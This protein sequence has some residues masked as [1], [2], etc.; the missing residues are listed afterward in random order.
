MKNIQN[1]HISAIFLLLAIFFVFAFFGNKIIYNQNHTSLSEAQYFS[2]HIE[3][4]S[5]KLLDVSETVIS[6][7]NT[8]PK[9]YWQK[10]DSTLVRSSYICFI[11]AGD[12][13]SYWSTNKVDVNAVNHLVH[14]NSI[15]V[16][17]LPS[18]WYLYISSK[19]DDL[20]ISILELIKSNYQLKNSVLTP[21]INADFANTA[22][23]TLTTDSVAATYKIHNSQNEF[24][25]GTQFE[26]SSDNQNPI[27]YFDL[28]LYL[29]IIAFLTISILFYISDLI[30][31]KN[32]KYL[33]YGI[34]I[35]V[36]GIVNHIINFPISLKLSPIFINQIYEIPYSTSIGNLLF[37][38]LL[39]ILLSFG[40]FILNSKNN[41]IVNANY[42]VVHY[43]AF[44]IY[45]F[46]IIY[47][48]YNIILSQQSSIFTENILNNNALLIS[49]FLIVLL[50]IGLY[51]ATIVVFKLKTSSK[52]PIVIP[53]IIIVIV[54]YIIYIVLSVPFA[55][56]IT[57]LAITITIIII[58]YLIISNLTDTF[59]RHIII[60]VLLSVTTAV[61]IGLAYKQNGDNYQKHIAN[62]LSVTN[63]TV[64]EKSFSNISNTIA[65]DAQ[66]QQLLHNNID[67]DNALQQ[68]LIANYFSNI[69]AK[70]NIQITNCGA[71]ELIEI[72]PERE[73]Y[74]CAEYFNNTINEFTTPVIDSVL[75]L[76][77]SNTESVYYIAKI[78]IPDYNNINKS[79]ILY[80]E[81]VST[82]VPEGFGYA[83]LL[84]DNQSHKLNLTEY[85]F[86]IYSNNQLVYKFGDYRYNTI[87]DI[88]QKDSY[89][90]F[91]NTNNYRHFALKLSANRYIIISREVTRTTLYLLVFSFIFIILSLLSIVIYVTVYARTVL[92][93]FKINF[94]TRLQTFIIAT[95]TL[96]F[97]IMG[98]TTMIYI[99]DSNKETLENQ[100]TE[101]A[102]SVLI[103]LQH[104]LSS[105]KDLKNED[106]EFL[107][108][109]LRKFS[110]VFF[111]DINLYDKSGELIATSRPEIF[112]K[113]LLST[114]INPLAYNAIF[115]KNKFNFITEENIG[116][117]KYYS[118]FVPINL[119]NNSPIG[120]VNLPYFARQ[121]QITKSYYIMMSYLI[122]I[123]V[124]IG[125]ISVLIAI[126]FSKYLT[127]PL[128]L[129]QE[130]MAAITI[131]KHNEK[132]LWN[133]SDEIGMLINEY[134]LMV[135]KLEQSAELLKHSER[136]SAW[137]QVA[138]Q[139]AHEIKNPL[140]PMKL[141][142]QF[143]QKAFLQNDD[144][145]P[146]KLH[147]ISKS[148]IT[149]IEVLNDVAEMFTDFAKSKSIKLKKVNLNNA[150]QA[151]VN[152]FSN[153][154][155]ISITVVY[156]N[157]NA[158]YEV[159]GFEK[160][161][162]RVITNLI[163]N[164]IQAVEQNKMAIVNISIT[165]DPEFI[166]V[167]VADNGKGISEKMKSQ[168]FQPYFTTKTSG[169]G[170]GLAIVK[171][172]MTEIGGSVSFEKAKENGTIFYLKFSY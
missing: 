34:A 96:T 110:L 23:I 164:A 85:S 99:K 91:F 28:L 30:I 157:I 92:N 83:S 133:K 24:I 90:T 52:L 73:I 77:N 169:T 79:R 170:L 144:N 132:I 165:K 54:I 22:N 122:N 74:E 63:D 33:Y 62:T 114:Y 51:Y 26:I 168:I 72:Q 93:I 101:K 112:E 131:D 156:D 137:R 48:L 47:L 146:E 123:Y 57:T 148:L 129:L 95:L 166:N 171:N 36:L 29:L 46:G 118:A 154:T 127:K 153:D 134:N 64:F 159:Y 141:N 142:V 163:K 88:N 161:I 38:S 55:I 124:I 17:N 6:I 59:L 14:D 108:Q 113:N 87:F 86:A 106:T 42:S 60:L 12:S 160:D 149:Q 140:T 1:R 76:F 109:L 56:I 135:D 5:V 105:V 145:F 2:E 35:L 78:Q 67:S 80:I 167:A 15:R 139:I 162:V 39:L 117:L 9:I 58:K 130:S 158:N 150:I 66:F 18:G 61:I 128:V 89:N 121:T 116:S 94:K 32:L 172:I 97:L 37:N 53:I 8:Y 4:Q 143:L 44:A 119:N 115:N 111:S 103:E 50:N 20:N 21:H 138:Q 102:N 104:K 125:I 70:Y 69:S 41:K 68:Y 75:F 25:V 65:H 43:L 49:I 10:L 27:S 98:I 31:N 19:Y 120:I 100:L 11:S 45:N 81:F 3:T 152:L 16:V 107:Q 126:I 40:V 147:S 71:N 13:I 151:S 84:I 136:E 7:V 82:H 155:N